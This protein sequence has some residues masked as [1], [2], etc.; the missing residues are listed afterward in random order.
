[1]KIRY[2]FVLVVSIA[3]QIT[4]CAIDPKMYEDT[5]SPKLCIDYLNS[6]T[7]SPFREAREAELK[8]RGENCST[9]LEAAQARREA[10]MREAQI[11]QQQSSQ[12]NLK[13][14]TRPDGWGGS[15]T[16]CKS[17]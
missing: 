1:M 17:E 10:D 15:T 3:S 16:N 12:S 11:R 13:C 5:P 9:Y 6:G 2:Q 4:A 14:A 8:R 7:L